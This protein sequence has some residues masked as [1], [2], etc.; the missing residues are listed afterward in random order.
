MFRWILLHTLVALSVSAPGFPGGHDVLHAYPLQG[1]H[2]GSH[3]YYAPAFYDFGYG[4]HDPYHGTNFGHKESRRGHVTQGE[5]FV[6]L[7]DGRLQKVTY[8]ADEHGYHPTVTYI[9]AAHHHH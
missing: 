9:G 6:H 2:Y 7:P 4:V 8:Y 1:G 5:Y 3:D